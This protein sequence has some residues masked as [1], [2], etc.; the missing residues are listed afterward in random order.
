MHACTLQMYGHTIHGHTCLLKYKC[1]T[2]TSFL[3]SLPPLRT[4][5]HFPPYTLPSI[6]TSY[7]LPFTPYTLPSSTHTNTL[8]SPTHQLSSSTQVNEH[9]EG[10]PCKFAILTKDQ[11]RLVSFNL[12]AP[13]KEDKNE[14]VKAIRTILLERRGP[15]SLLNSSLCELS[16][17]GGD[18]S[19]QPLD[20]WSGSTSPTG[21]PRASRRSM[22]TE[23]HAPLGSATTMVFDK[24]RGVGGAPWAGAGQGRY[25][26]C[27]DSMLNVSNCN[28]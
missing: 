3:P 23:D 7:T 15:K 20:A 10:D 9:L 22:S 28:K 17:V 26:L 13:S 1:F 5:T 2:P 11:N 16:G 18:S 6:H 8:L 21:S 27:G 25:T 14:S 12:K 4:S 19:L 24:V